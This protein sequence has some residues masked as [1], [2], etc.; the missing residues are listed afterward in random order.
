MEFLRD[1]KKRTWGE[2]ELEVQQITEKLMTR[3]LDAGVDSRS[4]KGAGTLL[5]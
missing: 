4:D 3:I 1:Q 2:V 5:R